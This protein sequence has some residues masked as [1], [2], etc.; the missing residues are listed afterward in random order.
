[1]NKSIQELNNK[2]LL[3]MFEEKVRCNHYCPC[4]C[5]HDVPFNMYALRDELS[6]RLNCISK[7]NRISYDAD[8]IICTECGKPTMHSGHVCYSCSQKR[9]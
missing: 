8:D 6:R 5:H 2:E 7:L 9:D 4:E 1:M 3:E